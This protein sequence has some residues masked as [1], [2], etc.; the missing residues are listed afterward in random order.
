MPNCTGRST[1]NRRWKMNF[2]S[3][4]N[5]TMMKQEF[6]DKISAE[7]SV[8]KKTGVPMSSMHS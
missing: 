5:N 7:N 4:E 3:G 6:F 2:E 1:A 8:G